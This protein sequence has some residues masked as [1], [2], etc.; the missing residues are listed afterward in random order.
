MDCYSLLCAFGVSFI[1][2]PK[3]SQ[4]PFSTVRMGQKLLQFGI[5][6]PAGCIIDC[7]CTNERCELHDKLKRRIRVIKQNPRRTVLICA[8]KQLSL[9][10]IVFVLCASWTCWVRRPITFL[11]Y[12]KQRAYWLTDEIY[13][14]GIK[15]WSWMT[16]FVDPRYGSSFIGVLKS[17][18]RSHASY[19]S[20][21]CA[22]SAELKRERT[23]VVWWTVFIWCLRS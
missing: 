6:S 5:S 4:K 17:G 9:G 21:A 2:T 13:T 10:N 20:G 8:D 18:T 15:I 14:V 16:T 22:A 7:W 1:R 11:S 3:S 19:S 23:A 12:N